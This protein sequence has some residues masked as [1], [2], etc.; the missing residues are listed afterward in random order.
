MK[1]ILAISSVFL[2]MTCVL[3]GCGADRNDDRNDGSYYENHDY[4]RTDGNSL[5]D[6]A[7]DAVDGAKNAG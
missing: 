4:G 7:R 5:E 2:M 3:T 6:H 1:K